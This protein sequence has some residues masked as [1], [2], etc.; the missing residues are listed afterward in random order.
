MAILKIYGDESG[1]MPISDNDGVFVAATVS[2]IDSSPD[3]KE[4]DGRIK[5]L[6]ERLKHLSATPFI[7]YV[8]PFAGYERAIKSKMEK[9]SIMARMTRLMTGANSQYITEKGIPVRNFIWTQCMDQ[10]IA[11]AILTKI[12]TT[13]VDQIEIILDQ[14][15]M[16]QQTREFFQDRVKSVEKYLR[17]SLNWAKAFDREKAELLTSHVAFSS[18]KIKLSWS[19]DPDTDDA[20][21]GLVLAHYLATHFQQDMAQ[22]RIPRIVEALSKEG[23]ENF[24]LDLT[25]LITKPVS[26]KAITSW[27]RNTGLKEPEI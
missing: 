3:L 20:K 2:T 15:T 16:M 8:K 25:N 10:A 13:K 22:N 17:N 27:E 6:A 26:R 19:D 23:F 9:M 24:S 1:T 21:G 5:W 18:H 12:S 14:K 11:H 7:I 4:I